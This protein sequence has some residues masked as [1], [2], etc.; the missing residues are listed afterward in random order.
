MVGLFACSKLCKNKKK[1][2]QGKSTARSV[3]LVSGS[4]EEA[5]EVKRVSKKKFGR[6]R[7]IQKPDTD[8]DSEQT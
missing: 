8:S 5:Q 3:N 6:I 2:Q 7:K 1:Q 4:E